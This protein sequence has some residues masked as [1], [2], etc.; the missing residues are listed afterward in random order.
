MQNQLE[1]IG[2]MKVGGPFGGSVTY[3]GHPF[4]EIVSAI[5]KY[6]RRG[7]L[8]KAYY[9]TVEADLYS[10]VPAGTKDYSNAK[11]RR[12][13]FINR[14]RVILG[15]EIGIASPSLILDFDRNYLIWLRFRESTQAAD[16]ETARRA[17]L[18]M[19]YLLVT[20]KKIRLVS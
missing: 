18:E 7:E 1:E 20:A 15:E 14:L 2:K 10:L 17:L 9:V 5:Q 13:A 16:I 3:N 12:T 6:I 19:V 8:E 4:D 11:S